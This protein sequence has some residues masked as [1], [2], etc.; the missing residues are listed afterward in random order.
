MNDD[1]VVRGGDVDPVSFTHHARVG[2][3]GR[4]QLHELRDPSSGGPRIQLALIDV[5]RGHCIA[6]QLEHTHHENRTVDD[7]RPSGAVDAPLQPAL[8]A[9]WTARCASRRLTA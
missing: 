8:T 4:Q 3:I 5:G 6:E 7:I 1:D 9:S 2:I